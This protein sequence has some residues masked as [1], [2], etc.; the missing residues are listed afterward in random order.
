VCVCVCVCVCVNARVCVYVCEYTRELHEGACVYKR[1]NT[2][3]CWKKQ[4]MDR[5][6]Q[7]TQQPHYSTHHTLPHLAVPSPR[8][9]AAERWYTNRV[10][11]QNSELQGRAVSTW[12]AQIFCMGVVLGRFSDWINGVTGR[13]GEHKPVVAGDSPWQRCRRGKKSV[14]LG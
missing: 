4:I 10:L 11:D 2:M 14:I 1:I 8:D 5:K 3:L 6:N 12:S 7:G 13:G 9:S